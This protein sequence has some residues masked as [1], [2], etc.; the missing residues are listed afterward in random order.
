MKLN[1]Q[2]VSNTRLIII[3]TLAFL[4]IA[5]IG[6]KLAA[7]DRPVIA[8]VGDAAFAMNGAEVHCAVEHDVPVVW[9]V[10]NNGGHGMVCHGEKLQFKGKFTTGRFRTPLDVA[11]MATAMGALGIRVS[12][13]GDFPKALQEALRSQRPTVIDVRTD[14]EEMPPL[15]MRIETLDRFFE[16]NG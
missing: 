3:Q 7:P 12:S 13:P 9:V 6:G 16:G 8:L 4:W 1:D 11:G 14:P 10:M 15:A 2:R 5:A